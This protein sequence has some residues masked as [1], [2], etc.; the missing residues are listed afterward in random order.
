MYSPKHNQP[1][2]NNIRNPKVKRWQ[3]ITLNK[4]L[5]NH[6]RLVS[7]SQSPVSNRHAY[8]RG[9]RDI[10]H[11]PPNPQRATQTQETAQNAPSM[12]RRFRY[13]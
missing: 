2:G 3:R 8:T 9:I 4:V 7:Q 12:Q 10:P 13:S 5:E 11:S 1:I 6:D